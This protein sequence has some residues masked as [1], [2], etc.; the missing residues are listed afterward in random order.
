MYEGEKMIPDEEII[1]V[2]TA[3]GFKDVGRSFSD[4][5]IAGVRLSEF[6][7]EFVPV[8]IHNNLTVF[9]HNPERLLIDQY[10]I[11]KASEIVPVL[12]RLTGYRIAFFKD[13][14]VLTQ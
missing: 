1:E 10:K 8:I 13:F 7:G 6:D 2:L 11:L 14:T 5:G 12:N 4:G 9:Q 3:E